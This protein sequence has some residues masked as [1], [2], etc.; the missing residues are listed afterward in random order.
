MN[1]SLPDFFVTFNWAELTQNAIEIL[2]FMES[3]KPKHPVFRLKSRLAVAALWCWTMLAAPLLAH[4]THSQLLADVDGKLR[5]NPTDGHIWFRR[6][7]LL[8]E[9]EDWEQALTDLERAE[10]L[11]PGELPTSLMRGRAMELASK[12]PEAKSALDQHI[13]R[14]PDDSRG[15]VTRAGVLWKLDA[16]EQSLADYRTALK[17]VKDLQPDLIQDA[18]SAMAA[19]GHSGEALDVLN[20]GIAKLG[21]I[22]ALANKALEIETAAGRY[23]AAL[24]RVEELQK[25]APRPEP[26]MARRASLIAQ[27]GR[28]DD[29]RT[30]WQALLTHI[31]KLPNL[32]RGSHSMQLLTEQ[33]QAAIEALRNPLSQTTDFPS[34]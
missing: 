16:R 26:W 23:D 25:T 28:H 11:L 4:G 33:A 7:C 30:A 17:M 32:E 5:E 14:F 10:K 9:H 12:L 8:V 15:Y 20:T 34:P 18:A 22:P 21:N 2:C 3:S 29:S 6:A 31:A 24:A 27:A 19:S 1:R 13:A